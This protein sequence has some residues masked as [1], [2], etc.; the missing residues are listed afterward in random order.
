MFY[1]SILASVGI[2]LIAPLFI[3]IVY[4]EAYLPSV[5]P[6]RVIVWYTAFS[7]LG[8]ARNAWVVCENKQKYLKYIYLGSALI[9]VGMNLLLIPIWGTVGAAVA[10]LLTQ[11]STIFIFP[12][13]FRE[14]RPNVRLMMEGILLKGVFNRDEEKNDLA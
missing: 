1:L 9:N 6:L 12:L 2:C 8:V 13:F 10:S 7:Y 14:L 5:S 11:F 4:G 3:R